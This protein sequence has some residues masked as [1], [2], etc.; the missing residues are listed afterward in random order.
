MN[1]KENSVEVISIKKVEVFPG[2][3]EEVKI[4]Q[5]EKRIKFHW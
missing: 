4:P 1:K 3:K 5:E 2:K